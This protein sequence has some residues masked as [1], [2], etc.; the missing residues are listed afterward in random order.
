VI[1]GKLE[2]NDDRFT[3]TVRSVGLDA[4]RAREEIKETGKLEDLFTLFDRVAGRLVPSLPRP[5]GP[6]ELPLKA[7]EQY[8]KGLLAE[9]PATRLKFLDAALKLYPAYDRA[10]LA[11]WQAYTDQGEYQRA[12]DIVK[13][14][15]AGSR[16]RRRA[17]FLASLSQIELKQYDQAFSE[18]KALLDEQ[19]TPALHNNLGIVQL[20]RGSSASS[21][22]PTYF[23]TRATDGDQ[24]DPDYCF[25]LGYAYWLERDYPAA[26]YWLREALR[27]DPA[28]GDAHFVLG[29]VLQSIEPGIEAVREQELARQ[30]SSKYEDWP[31]R[32]GSSTEQVPRGLERIKVD[33]DTP[34]VA[35]MDATILNTV[36]REQREVAAYHLTNGQRLF[37]EEKDDEAIMEL[38]RA[39]FLSPYLPEAHLTLGRI[40]FRR[41]RVADAIA[42]FKVSVW[43]QEGVP[44]RLALAEAY[45]H[46]GDLAAARAEAERARKLEPSSADSARVL[47]AIARREAGEGKK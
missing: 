26:A 44:A 5:D 15:P 3:V 46:N 37:G 13:V 12:L 14:V 6:A 40:Y 36:R 32:P 30:L 35:Q 16:F 33:L 23:F 41:G 28:D 27:R 25:N 38:R 29:V 7:F 39:L 10:R 43:S 31:R 45:L 34:R 47:E 20:R 1:T 24:G 17:L 4:G 9:T 11:L 18:L 21:G 8:I 2:L 19:P 42:A 22:R